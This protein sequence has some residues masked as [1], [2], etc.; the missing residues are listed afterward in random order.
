M[1]CLR[2][3]DSSINY[4]I[5][6]QSKNPLGF[7]KPWSCTLFHYK[8][9]VNHHTT[10]IKCLLPSYAITSTLLFHIDGEIFINIFRAIPM[11]GKIR[12]PLYTDGC[13]GTDSYVQYLEHVQARIT[14]TASRRG[15]IQIFLISPAGTRSTLLARRV[16]D[17]SREGFNNWAFM[18]THNWGERASGNWV[19]EI[20]NGAS[21]CKDLFYYIYN[22][23]EGDHYLAAWVLE[24]YR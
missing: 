15:E 18:T 3:V 2:N 16:R 12:V 13:Q 5:N 22:L 9:T 20:Q 11:N 7:W 1:I 24:I 14:L 10:I 4:K 17:T 23:G 19:L 6:R 21:A 8:D